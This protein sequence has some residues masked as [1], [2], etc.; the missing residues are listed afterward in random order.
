M[1]TN[2]LKGLTKTYEDLPGRALDE[3]IAEFT[4]IA[5]RHG[6]RMMR[7]Y[8]LTA[9]PSNRR[10]EGDIASVTMKG[11]PSGFWVWRES[12]TGGHWIRR[13]KAVRPGGRALLAGDLSHP[14]VGPVYHTGS[15]GH[16]AWTKTVEEADRTIAGIVHKQTG[17]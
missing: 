16:G 14:L 12:G 8:Q 9:K 1:G 10:V 11:V 15:L 2:V 17:L 4:R 13:K 7:K 3:A 6:G 5:E